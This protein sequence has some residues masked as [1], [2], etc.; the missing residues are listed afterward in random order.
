M[1]EKC[2]NVSIENASRGSN[3]GVKWGENWRI[4]YGFLAPRFSQKIATVTARTEVRTYNVKVDTDDL[5][6][7]HAVL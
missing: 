2:F 7:S 5:N 4:A 3:I 1:L 6:L